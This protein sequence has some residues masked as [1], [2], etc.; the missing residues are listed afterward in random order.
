MPEYASFRE[1]LPD[2]IARPGGQ[3]SLRGEAPGHLSILGTILSLTG[4][5]GLAQGSC[6]L[7]FTDEGAELAIGYPPK[8]IR[9]RYPE[10]SSFQIAGRGDVVTT[11]GGGW[12]GGALFPTIFGGTGSDPV[13]RA[14][15]AAEAVFEGVALRAVL[16]WLT[17]AKHHHVETI[18]YLAWDSGAI[19]LL[20]TTMRPTEWVI[21]LSPVLQRIEERRSAVPETNTPSPPDEKLCPYCAETIKAAAIKCRY[22]GS[23]LRDPM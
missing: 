22:C 17:S 9:L 15:H 13:A 18:F 6:S 3:W 14:G 20:N 16:N 5:S 11:T 7:T 4:V 10:I 1:G 21:R 2:R 12:R 23:D 8:S 19:S